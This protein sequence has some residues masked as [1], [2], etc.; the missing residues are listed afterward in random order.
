M[1]EVMRSFT[2]SS[3]ISLG[4][5]QIQHSSTV[6]AIKKDAIGYRRY[7]LP[8]GSL[9]SLRASPSSESCRGGAAAQS[10]ALA[11]AAHSAALAVAA[12]AAA[13]PRLPAVG[14]PPRAPRPT[15]GDASLAPGKPSPPPRDSFGGVRVSASLRSP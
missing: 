7:E 13:G 2:P 4:G 1:I 14:A 9:F 15:L 3:V 6:V 5:L 12:A 10:A 11:A 8:F